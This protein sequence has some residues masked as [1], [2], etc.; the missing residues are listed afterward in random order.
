VLENETAAALFI[1]LCPEAIDS[2]LLNNKNTF[3]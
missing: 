3:A 1:E 2:D